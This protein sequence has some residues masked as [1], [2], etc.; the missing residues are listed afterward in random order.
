[1]ATTNGPNENNVDLATAA[2][3]AYKSGDYELAIRLFSE[4][5]K[6]DPEL[7]EARL[8]LGMAY[9]KTSNKSR[10]M[11]EF[12]DIVAWC[13][14]PAIKEKAFTALKGLSSSQSPHQSSSN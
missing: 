2:L 9:F 4:V 7:W 13:K 12:K 14:D 6:Q 3:T 8:Y 10:A 1:M 5:T 11:Q